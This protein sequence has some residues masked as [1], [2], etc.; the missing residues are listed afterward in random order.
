MKVRTMNLTQEQMQGLEKGEP[1][2]V[3]IGETRCVLVREDV[4]ES[5]HDEVDY[6]P[7]TV[8]EMNLL[9]DEASEII[10]RSEADD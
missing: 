1:I 2:R 9:A 4:Y 10:S 6:G 8:E 7:W 5:D 3:T